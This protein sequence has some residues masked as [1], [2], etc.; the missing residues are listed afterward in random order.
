[1]EDA[2]R[3][4]EKKKRGGGQMP[5]GFALQGQKEGEKG[6][7]KRRRLWSQDL[8]EGEKKKEKK[9][10][11]EERGRKYCPCPIS[12]PLYPLRGKGGNR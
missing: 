8:V 12:P 3:E 6:G 9:K 5:E 7:G 4:R 10:T 11:G 1:M 2:H